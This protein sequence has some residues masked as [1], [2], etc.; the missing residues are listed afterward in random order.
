MPR[1]P[2][3]VPATTSFTRVAAIASY[4]G[5]APETTQFLLG[6]ACRRI[7]PDPVRRI[8]PAERTRFRALIG[9]FPRVRSGIDDARSLELSLGKQEVPSVSW[10]GGRQALLVPS[11][12]TRLSMPAAK[13]GHPS[14]FATLCVMLR[15]CGEGRPR[16]RKTP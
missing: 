15:E 5:H 7:G 4:R 11:S 16:D 12:G 3:D 9:P 1:W 6:K 13:Q 8:G 14:V 2:S 10:Q